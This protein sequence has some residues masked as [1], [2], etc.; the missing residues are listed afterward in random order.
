M[1]ELECCHYWAGTCEEG[2]LNR[3]CSERNC[4]YKKLELAEQKLEK[5]KPILEHYANSKLGELQPDG[6]YKFMYATNDFVSS[7]YNL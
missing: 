7:V 2:G 4:Y 6:T 5:I 1:S 3:K